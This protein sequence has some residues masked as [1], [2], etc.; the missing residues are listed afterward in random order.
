VSVVVNNGSATPIGYAGAKAVALAVGGLASDDDG[1]L[2][3][4]GYGT[5]TLNMPIV[6]G[7][8]PATVDLSGFADDQPITSSLS[9]SNAEGQTFAT[10]NTVTLDQDKTERYALKLNVTNSLIGA[11]G[12]SAVAFTIAGLEPEDTGTKRPSRIAMARL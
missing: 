1:W 6:N 7:V 10:G 4:S 9:V 5:N 12:A 11:A 3:F 2:T 8:A